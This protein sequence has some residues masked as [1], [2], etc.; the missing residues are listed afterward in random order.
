MGVEEGVFCVGC[1]AGLMLVL[2]AVG[3]S[4]VGWMAAVAA[5]I[6]IEKVLAPTATVAKAVAVV[7][8]AFGIAVASISSVGSLVMAGPAM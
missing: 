7:L 4:S 5:V 1:C 2:L 3:L 6:F 8:V